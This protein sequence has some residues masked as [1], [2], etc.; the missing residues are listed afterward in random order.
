MHQVSNTVFTSKPL[1]KTLMSIVTSN[2]VPLLNDVKPFKDTWKVEVKVL[3]SWTQHST[4][5]GGNSL[6]FILADK[7]VSVLLFTLFLCESL[8]CQKSK[9]IF[10]VPNV[11]C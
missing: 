9:P 8:Y 6:D 1:S 4:Y 3:H 11:G 5:A 2:A 10:I 7:T